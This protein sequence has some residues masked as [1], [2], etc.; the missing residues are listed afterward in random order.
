MG[1]AASI[2]AGSAVGIIARHRTLADTPLITWRVLAVGSSVGWST[3]A[4]SPYAIDMGR[5]STRHPS[6]LSLHILCQTTRGRLSLR[7]LR[8][9]TAALVLAN[10]A[11]STPV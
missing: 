6:A 5:K 2:P 7:D 10:V 1:S 8:F 4:S 3:Q 11:L 9:W